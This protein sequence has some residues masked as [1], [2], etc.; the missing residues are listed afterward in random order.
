LIQVRSSVALQSEEILESKAG[1]F[2]RP[3]ELITVSF[4]TQREY[5]CGPAALATTLFYK[6][7]SSTRFTSMPAVWPFSATDL[8]ISSVRSRDG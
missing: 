4:N 1:D 7:G 8:Y 3:Q 2:L 6:I 5:R